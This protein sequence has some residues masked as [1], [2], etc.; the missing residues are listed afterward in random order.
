MT[1]VTA[2]AAGT[3]ARAVAEH[4]PLRRRP[5][6]RRP[7]RAASR[8]AA[9]RLR[10]Q[11]RR[12]AAA[13]SDGHAPASGGEGLCRR[14]RRPASRGDS[15]GP[16]AAS[17]GMS[18]G[19][20]GRRRRRWSPRRGAG[21]PRSPPTAVA[22]DSSGTRVAARGTPAPT[23]APRSRPFSPQ[24]RWQPSTPCPVLQPCRADA[25]RRSAAGPTLRSIDSQHR[26]WPGF[27]S[28][29]SQLR[30]RADPSTAA[31]DQLAGRPAAGGECCSG[32][33]SPPR[34]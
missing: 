27:Q 31:P 13:A 21:A 9:A 14:R 20:A 7:C 32:D 8:A 2:A 11:C 33:L 24:R 19:L 6:L 15:T 5:R 16:A 29:F 34:R 26:S 22:H 25:C 23:H 1:A 4:R 18:R 10:A 17:R 30:S 12:S 3:A 28:C